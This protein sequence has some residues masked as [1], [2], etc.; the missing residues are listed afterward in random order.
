MTASS[1]HQHKDLLNLRLATILGR[2]RGSGSLDCVPEAQRPNKFS[3]HLRVTMLAL[4]MTVP[5]T[6]W[7]LGTCSVHTAG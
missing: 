5:D 3:L 6:V 4:T 1:H 2:T 7:R